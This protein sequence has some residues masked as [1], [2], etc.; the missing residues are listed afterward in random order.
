M[1]SIRLIYNV[2]VLIVVTYLVLIIILVVLIMMY[3]EIGNTISLM[4][5]QI[6]IQI[7]N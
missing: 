4:K 2:L 5:S 1:L 6:K 3:F 7:L